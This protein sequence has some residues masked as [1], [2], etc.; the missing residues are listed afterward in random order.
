MSNQLCNNILESVKK[1]YTNRIFGI[2]I[3]GT[4]TKEENY[5]VMN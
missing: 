1:L 4:I 2:E 3:S 5:I